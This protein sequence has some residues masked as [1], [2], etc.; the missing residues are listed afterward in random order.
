MTY[1]Q[2]V[3]TLIKIVLCNAGFHRRD[4]HEKI[5]F[6]PYGKCLW[7][8][9]E[10]IVGYA[11]LEKNIVAYPLPPDCDRVISATIQ[12]YQDTYT[13]NEHDG[14]L[15]VSPSPLRTHV[16]GVKIVYTRKITME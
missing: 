9:Q 1:P 13:V 4:W 7:C 10:V 6:Q 3:K 8:G 16:R 2:K 12:G 11:D 15:L 14:E 5:A